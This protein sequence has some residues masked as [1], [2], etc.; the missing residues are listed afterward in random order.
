M[1]QHYVCD[2][3]IN[4]LNGFCGVLQ[5]GHEAARI[6]SISEPIQKDENENTMPPLVENSLKNNKS[7]WHAGH[8]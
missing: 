4:Y 7:I 2:L 3:L 5:L 8:S 6:L 1:K